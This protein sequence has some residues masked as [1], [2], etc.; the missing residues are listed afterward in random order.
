M[1]VQARKR[2]TSINRY[3]SMLL[4]ELLTKQSTAFL[5]SKFVAN[6]F[7]LC[8]TQMQHLAYSF[9]NSTARDNGELASRADGMERD[10]GS[11]QSKASYNLLNSMSSFETMIFL[12]FFDW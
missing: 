2:Y 3:T 4:H 11:R 7:Q 12:F 5:N 1:L 10:R 9:R 6:I 8:P